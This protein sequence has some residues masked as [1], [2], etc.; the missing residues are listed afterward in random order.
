MVRYYLLEFF[1]TKHFFL[2]IFF[3]VFDSENLKNR[4]KMAYNALLGAPKKAEGVEFSKNSKCL[5]LITTQTMPNAIMMYS[6]VGLMVPPFALFWALKIWKPLKI[7]FSP[8]I[9]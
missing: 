9:V 8:I 4:T 7:K 3:I 6:R 1:F 2:V 5:T